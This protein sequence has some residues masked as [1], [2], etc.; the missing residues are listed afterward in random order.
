MP[1]RQL[2]IAQQ[3]RLVRTQTFVPK[4]RIASNPSNKCYEEGPARGC[5]SF[6]PSRQNEEASLPAFDHE[7]SN[8][9]LKLRRHA[10]LRQSSRYEQ[11]LRAPL[12][13]SRRMPGL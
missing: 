2:M 13:Q 4:R 6:T 12:R 3:A 1:C 9:G 5:S 8:D 10:G 7:V 11:E